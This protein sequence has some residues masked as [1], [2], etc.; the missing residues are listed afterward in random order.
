MYE[1]LIILFIC[2]L[3]GDF[4]FQSD[5]LA[6]Y[7]GI[8][9]YIMFIHCCIWS[10]V[11]FSG[12]WFV[13]YNTGIGTFLSLVISHYIIDKWKCSLEDKTK[14]LT[15]DLYVDQALHGLIIILIYLILRG[16]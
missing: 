4:V 3:F 14:A 16:I 7:K 12:L 2:H 15:T 13:S 1:N 5:F 10:G 6:K 8:N 9:D 11:V